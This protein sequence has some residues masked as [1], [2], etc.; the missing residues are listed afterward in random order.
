M[1]P[2]EPKKPEEYISQFFV[3][4]HLPSHLRGVSKL[5]KELHDK[6]IKDVPRSVERTAAL[7]KLLESKDAAVRAV[8]AK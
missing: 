6:I 4:E 5:F 8:V 1:T 3:Y 2:I 7:R